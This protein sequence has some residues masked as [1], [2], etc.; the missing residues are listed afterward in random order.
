MIKLVVID[1]DGT[2]LDE[3]HCIS[4][5]SKQVLQQVYAQGIPLMLATGRHYQDVYL[6]A[7]Q[8]DIPLYLITSNGA[9]VHARDGR[10][11]YKNH[12]PPNLVGE[13]LQISKGYE[14]H[15]NLY[16]QDLWLVEEPNEPLL[17]IHHASGFAY[18]ITDFANIDY[19]H[20]DKFYF[21]AP[22]E[23]LKPLQQQLLARFSD[24]LYI[25]FTTEIYLEIMNK[26]VSKGQA[27]QQMLAIKGIKPSEVMAFGDGLNDVDMLNL[28]GHPVLMANAHDELKTLVPQAKKTL[29]NAQNGVAYY[30]EEQV[31]NRTSINP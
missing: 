28:V 31:L 29:S 13:I 17:N 19:N 20:I 15:R 3:N 4:A 16:Q 10:L 6:L 8:I 23:K 18:R 1:L 21:N 11:L 12:I 24:Q 22:Y 7:K 5:Q 30:L 9:R 26:G 14:V 25:T 27:L 2:L